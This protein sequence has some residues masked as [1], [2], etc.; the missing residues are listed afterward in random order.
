M[1][2]AQ[3]GVQNRDDAKNCQACGASLK[4]NPYQTAGA[5]PAGSVPNHLWLAILSTVFCF[6][7]F[8]IVAIVYAIRV[9]NILARGDYQG[10]VQASRTAK[11]WCWLSVGL[12]LVFY[13][14]GVAAF[15]LAGAIK[16]LPAH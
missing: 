9:D 10:A 6:F 13:V 15:I 7:P 1:F 11:I 2:C 5:L 12:G 3:C 16:A 14:L 4:P 8:G